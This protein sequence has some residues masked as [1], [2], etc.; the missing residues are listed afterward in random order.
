ML[1]LGPLQLLVLMLALT[2]IV[3]VAGWLWWRE[4]EDRG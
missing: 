1:S 2:M 4:L 3:G